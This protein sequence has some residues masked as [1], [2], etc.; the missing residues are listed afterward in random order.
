MISH[1]NIIRLRD[2]LFNVNNLLTYKVAICVT[3]GEWCQRS[4]WHQLDLAVNSIPKQS[5]YG[6]YVKIYF[7]SILSLLI[8]S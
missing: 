3:Y 2:L 8:F 4:H 7:I 1:Y 6:D 5:F